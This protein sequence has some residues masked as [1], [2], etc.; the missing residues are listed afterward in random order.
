MHQLCS[1]L[2]LSDLSILDN[3]F[4]QCLSPRLILCSLRSVTVSHLSLNH[5]FWQVLTCL[6]SP[7]TNMSCFFLFF[8][9]FLSLTWPSTNKSRMLL[10]LSSQVNEMPICSSLW[11]IVWTFIPSW[12]CK[13]IGSEEGGPVIHSSP[14]RLLGHYRRGRVQEAGWRLIPPDWKP[15][16]FCCFVLWSVSSEYCMAV[17]LIL[18]KNLGPS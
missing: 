15:Q 10:L 16:A 17:S 2:Y 9:D 6:W 12:N 8:I 14:C 11:S 13:D 7:F 3:I 5:H 4:T 18:E 1:D